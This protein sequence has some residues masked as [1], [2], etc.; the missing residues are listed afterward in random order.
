MT[1]T[2]HSHCTHAATKSAR[3][4]CRKAHGVATKGTTVRP[5]GHAA[6]HIVEPCSCYRPSMFRE[7]GRTLVCVDCDR[8]REQAA[9]TDLGTLLTLGLAG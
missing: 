5:E 1:N 7:V 9:M 8:P 6:R 3:A 4:A 2:A